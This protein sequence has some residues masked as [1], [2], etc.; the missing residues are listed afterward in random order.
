M[1]DNDVDCYALLLVYDLGKVYQV[2]DEHVV[3]L[4][5]EI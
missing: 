4:F 1:I 5:K 2:V 3:Q